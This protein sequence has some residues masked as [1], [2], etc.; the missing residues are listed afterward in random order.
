MTALKLPISV[1]FISFL[2][3]YDGLRDASVVCFAAMKDKGV[4]RIAVSMGNN[5]KAARDRSS[6][7]LRYV[8]ESRPSWEIRFFSTTETHSPEAW[9]S[10]VLAWKPDAVVLCASV[11]PWARRGMRLV[12]ASCG[13]VAFASA[14]EARN[15]ML[16]QRTLFVDV[17][18]VEIAKAAFSLLSRRGLAHFAFAHPGAR[19]MDEDRARRR[20]APFRKTVREGGFDFR[21]FGKEDSPSEMGPRLRDLAWSLSSMPHPCGVLAYND[22]CAREVMDACHLAGLD[23]P[24]QIQIVGV[25]NQ[26]DIC[27]NVRPRLTSVVPDFEGAGHLMARR[28]DALLGRGGAVGAAGRELPPR[29]VSC[30][31]LRVAERDT[32]ID[33]SG[34]ARL[35]TA[36]ER[37][38]RECACAGLEGHSPRGLTPDALAER[39]HV[40]RRLLEIRFREVRGEGVAEAIRKRKLEE[41]RRQLRET[42][43]PIGVIADMCGFPAVAHFCAAFGRAYGLSPRAYRQQSRRR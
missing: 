17:S 3:K 33:L 29:V 42:D 31:V 20:A 10:S 37:V 34:A 24:K 25:D 5:L 28:L 16:P 36:A 1:F 30:G 7:F 22:Q 12:P 9:R 40:S 26:E 4:F 23:I 43:R 11:M 8:A 21:E 13:M 35:V 39:L 38:V 18:D 32:T 41:V 15:G 27:E 2:R 6:G 19:L 14:D